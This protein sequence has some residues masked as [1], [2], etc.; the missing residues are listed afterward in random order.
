MQD[1]LRIE[2]MLKSG[3]EL[4]SASDIELAKKCFTVK[5]TPKRG[6]QVKEN[7][8]AIEQLRNSDSGYFAIYSTEFK[9]AEQAMFAY[10]LRDGIEKRF[11]DLKNE[12]DMH[13]IRVH[14]THNLQSRLF[15]QFIAQILRCYTLSK[16]QSGQA[17]QLSK[18]QSMTDLLW[19][20]ASLRRVHVEGHRPFYKR[21]TKT[22]R[23]IF[24]LF[25]IPMDTKA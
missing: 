2:E 21:P 22:Q 23:E 13:R 5:N 20:V 7:L 11:D 19:N 12:E 6:I 10:K 9:D 4:K 16:L 18:I 24:T 14:S 8:E 17:K 3:Q 1:L 25:G 15:I